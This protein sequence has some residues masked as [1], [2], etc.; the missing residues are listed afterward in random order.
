MSDPRYPEQFQDPIGQL[1][2]LKESDLERCLLEI[3]IGCSAANGTCRG[4]RS[5]G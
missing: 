1:T 3:K 5:I 2:E 4:I